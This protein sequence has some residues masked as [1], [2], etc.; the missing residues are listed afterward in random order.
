MAYTVNSS[1]SLGSS[2][3]HLAWDAPVPC[4]R[5]S[6]GPYPI[7]RHPIGVPSGDAIRLASA[8]VVTTD[9]MVRPGQ[10]KV[11]APTGGNC[12][13]NGG[14]TLVLPPW[15]RSS[16]GQP[17]RY[18]KGEGAHLGHDLAIRLRDG[19]LPPPRVLPVRPA[20]EGPSARLGR[21]GVSRA[22]PPGH[23]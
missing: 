14:R 15:P 7:L 12:G 16:P 10:G 19:G 2:G 21:P 9:P 22:G 6:G 11:N 3:S 23:A 13:P 5:T 4:T 20:H 1:E 18:R 17:G 8:S